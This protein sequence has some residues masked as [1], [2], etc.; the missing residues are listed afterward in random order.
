VIHT[1]SP[2]RRLQRGF[3]LIELMITVAIIGILARVAVPAYLDYVKRG[4]LAEAFNQLS[5]CSMTMGQY[6]QDN[7]TYVGADTSTTLASCLTASTNFKYA[8]SNLSATGYTMTATGT[9]TSA[10]GF[11]FTVDASGTRATTAAP[12]G[13]TTSTSCWM[14]SRNGCQ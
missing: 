5:S 11:T 13:W 7:R 8:L 10:T 2:H 14:N 9:S 6:Y 3:T 12:S 4:K 1:T